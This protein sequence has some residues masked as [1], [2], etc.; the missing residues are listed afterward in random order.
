MEAKLNDEMLKD[1]DNR[2]VLWKGER[3]KKIEI[4]LRF[5][6]SKNGAFDVTRTYYV[7]DSFGTIVATGVSLNWIIKIFNE[8]I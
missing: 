4:V 1:F 3:G 7:I 2:V 8:I 6:K 5:T